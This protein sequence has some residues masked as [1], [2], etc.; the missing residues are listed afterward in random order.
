[1]INYPKIIEELGN[2][3]TIQNLEEVKKLSQDYYYFSPIL[4]SIL[5]DKTADL[6]VIPTSEKEVLKVAQICVKYQIPITVRGAGTGNYGQCI[7]LNG[8]IVLD[9]TQMKK[10]HWIKSGVACVDAGI[11]M[12]V[13]ERETKKQGWELRMIPSTY[14]IA[15]LGGFIGGGSGGIGSINYGQLRDRGNLNKVRVITLEK[16]PKIIELKGDETQQ[17]N[18]A[19]GTNGIITQ[20][21][22]P[23]APTYNWIDIIVTFDDFITSVKFGQA[24]AD[25]DGIIKKLISIHAKPIASYFTALKSYLPKGE[26]CALLTIAENSLYPLQE[27][28]NEYQGKITYQQDLSKENNI[29]LIEFTWNHTTFHVRNIEP[30]ITYLQTF[31]FTIDK[32]EEMYNYFGDEV[33]MHLE[34]LRVEGKAIPAGLQLVKFSTEERLNEIIKYHE[35]N[36]AF[37]ANPHTYILED[38]GRKK[39]DIEQLNFKKIVDPYGLMNQGKM[40]AWKNN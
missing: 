4:A 21:E 31:F 23:L 26:N 14:K 15:T 3:K 6:V 29:N 22:I 38:G 25:S 32:V 17:I 8:G 12:S 18:H 9:M 37:I 28:V 19:Y 40:K 35:K 2:I 5:Q 33:M 1:M 7:P 11:K 30:N 39:I 20:L 36:G 24:L 13:L 27:L 16:E 10:I 34:F